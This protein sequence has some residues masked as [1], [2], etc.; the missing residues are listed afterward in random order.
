MNHK[1]VCVCVCVC[2]NIIWG[3]R[4]KETC[5][6]FC[7]AEGSPT[8]DA[9]SLVQLSSWFQS[10]IDPTWSILRHISQRKWR[11]VLTWMPFCTAVFL[12]GKVRKFLNWKGDDIVA[13]IFKLHW[14][15][16]IL[17]EITFRGVSLRF[18][19]RQGT[20]KNRGGIF[21]TNWILLGFFLKKKKH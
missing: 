6:L 14:N 5:L 3:K 21:D 1:C 17:S 7:L 11:F 12:P 19:E 2:R 10:W 8:W 9:F 16:K 18:W 13:L 4:K 20:C 15:L